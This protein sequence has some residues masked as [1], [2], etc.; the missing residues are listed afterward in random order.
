MRTTASQRDLLAV[1]ARG[2]AERP[3]VLYRM[4][5]GGPAASLRGTSSKWPCQPALKVGMSHR[6]K[7]LQ[8]ARRGQG[9]AAT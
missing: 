8:N 3:W 6:A 2:T 1:L 4:R 5:A 9:A 7:A